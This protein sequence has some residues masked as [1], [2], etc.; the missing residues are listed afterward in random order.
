MN[1]DELLEKVLKEHRNEK[2]WYTFSLSG[3]RWL[4]S[5][6]YG[7]YTNE[8]KWFVTTTPSASGLV[9]AEHD[10][11]TF[12]VTYKAWSSFDTAEQAIRAVL[13]WC[14]GP[15]YHLSYKNY[16]LTEDEIKEGGGPNPP[17]LVVPLWQVPTPWQPP[18]AL[19]AQAMEVLEFENREAGG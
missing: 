1:H 11:G 14:D 3:R 6:D 5:H 17:R 19:E 8:D 15:H 7:R 9:Y 13:T 4:V 10:G 16:L 2:V 12:A 18:S